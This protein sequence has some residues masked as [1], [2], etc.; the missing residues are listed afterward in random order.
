MHI[1]I[2]TREDV[3]FS[4]PYHTLTTVSENGRK[5]LQNVS[6]LQWSVEEEAPA[7]HLLQVLKTDGWILREA[8]SIIHTCTSGYTTLS[9]RLERTVWEAVNTGLDV[10]SG[11]G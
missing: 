6:G 3:K 5:M 11:D 4:A 10:F 8:A 1:L 9:P 2:Y 7:S